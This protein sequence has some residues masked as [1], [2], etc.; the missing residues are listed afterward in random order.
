[1]ITTVFSSGSY[2]WYKLYNVIFLRKGDNLYLANNNISN[3]N[4]K[5]TLFI[6]EEW[7]VA[8]E[9]HPNPQKTQKSALH[10][11]K[12]V[13]FHQHN[14]MCHKSL[15]TMAKL[16]FQLLSYSVYSPRQKGFG[17]TKTEAQF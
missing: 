16:Y 9:N 14:I 11:Y 10:A 4:I 15:V 17:P 13:L 7:R 5:N 12:K 8:S 2:A 3:S 6:L 1:M